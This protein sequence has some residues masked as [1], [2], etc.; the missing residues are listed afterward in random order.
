MAAARPHLV[1]RARAALGVA[2]LLWL[3]ACMSSAPHETAARP[4]A[5]PGA[6][7]KPQPGVVP[8]ARPADAAYDWHGLV[9]APFGSMLK[10][11]PVALHE[12]LLF[13]DEA[14]AAA[15]AEDRDCYAISGAAPSFAGRKLDEYLL[16]FQHDRL[17][18]IEATVPL[19]ADEAAQ[20]LSR[21]CAMW[22]KQAAPLGP[23]DRLEPTDS[24]CNG[25][26]GGIGF[27]AHLGLESSE[28]A[29]LLSIALYSAAD[30]DAE[31]GS[32]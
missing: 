20:V 28:S 21:A 8:D 30:R 16:C 5:Q 1:L 14:H 17:S 26:E 6:Q 24:G 31:H 10:D 7:L 12:V 18:R 29:V 22:L 3:V 2:A 11:I 27:S 4:S 19:P 25:R 13:R 15:E 9:T 32:Q 23:A